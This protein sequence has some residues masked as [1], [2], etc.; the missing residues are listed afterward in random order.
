MQHASL[1]AIMIKEFNL[2]NI[3]K[4]IFGFRNNFLYAKNLVLYNEENLK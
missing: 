4:K 3:F 1:S 2:K